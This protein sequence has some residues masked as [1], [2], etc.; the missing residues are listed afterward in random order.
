MS[1]TTLVIRLGA[2]A[3]TRAFR[4]KVRD[5][6]L[7]DVLGLVGLSRRET[8]Y[9]QTLLLFG[10]GAA[11]G[12]GVALLLAPASGR[13]TRKLLGRR[14]EKL[15]ERASEADVPAVLGR[16]V[17]PQRANGNNNGTSSGTHRATY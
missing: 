6:D 10:G 1:L 3:I 2:T 15:R 5:L 14:L 8:H 7:N 13:E 17:T 9:G 11:V 16:G 4:R 12:V